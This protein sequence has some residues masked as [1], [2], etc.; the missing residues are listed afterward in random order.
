MKRILSVTAILTVLAFSAVNGQGTG[1]P[2]AQA[3]AFTV[4]VDEPINGSI[5]LNPTLPADGKVAAGTVI[6]ITATPERGF[7][8]DALYYSVPGMYGAMYHDTPSVS[9]LEVTVDQ[10]KYVGAYFIEASALAGI[11]VTHDVVYAQP[12]VKPLK[13]DVYAPEGAKDL[14]CIVIIHGGGWRSNDEDIMRGLARELAKSGKYVVFSIDYRWLGTLDGDETDN[15]MADLIEDV[16]GALAHIAEHARE[17]GGDPTRIAVTGDSAGGHL[18]AAAAT[19]ADRIGDGGF[20]K[21]PGM[22]EYLPTYVPANKT[23]EQ[24]RA[25]MMS[26]IK[27]A[28]PSYGVF[29]FEGSDMLQFL[30]LT[31]ADAAA[32]RAISPINNIPSASERSIPHYLTRGTLD[33]IIHDEAVKAYMDALV[34]RG[35]TVEYVQ[36]GGASHAFFDWK[37]NPAVEAVFAQFGVYYAEEM[38]HFFDAVFYSDD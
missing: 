36:I 32:I 4:I 37:P 14:P 9:T 17:Y 2:S 34:A 35:Q 11:A 27:A 15:T 12:G 31:D 19:M 25:E 22:F 33:P 21:T 24:V 26:A 16:Y 28:A 8:V 6:T 18:S 23:V 30:N 1:N 13:Y 10:D 29:A 20:G 5:R 7:A 38:A 3:A